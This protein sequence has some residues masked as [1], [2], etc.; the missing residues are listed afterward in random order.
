MRHTRLSARR[1]F[2]AICFAL[3]LCAAEARADHT[4]Y[5]DFTTRGFDLSEYGI[6]DAYTV[7]AVKSLIRELM[8][9]D[10]ASY[11]VNFVT[12][13]PPNGRYTRVIFGGYDMRSGSS[14][15]G[16]V[17][18]D[19][20]DQGF[21]GTGLGSWQQDESV[22]FV[23]SD[24]FST[25]VEWQG[26]DATA[27]RI[28][29][30]IAGTASHELGHILS[31]CHEN[32]YDDG[33]A[34]GDTGTDPDVNEH[35]M[36]TGLTG[37]QSDDRA[38]ADRFFSYH[39][40]SN[41]LLEAVQTRC[42]HTAMG[43]LNNSDARADLLYGRFQSP[44]EVRWYGRKSSG[45]AFGDY[46]TW[47]T[48]GGDAD[49]IFLAGDVDNDK[50]A[51]LVYGRVFSATKV[52]WYVRKSDGTKFGD[53]ATWATDA[54]D[55]G[56]IFRLADVNAD[57]RADLVYGR[58]F[59]S[60]QVTWYVRKS[61]GSSFGDYET[62]VTDGGDEGNIFFVA[63]V[64][65]NKRADLVYGYIF[66]PTQ[67]TWYVRKSSGSSFGGYETWVTDGGDEGDRFLVADLDADGDAD[68]AYGR[69][70]GADFSDQSVVIWYARKS[71]GTK[72]GD[73]TTWSSDAGDAGDTFRI[74][75]L[76]GDKRADLL[77]GRKI[78]FDTVKWYARNSSGSG[79]GG[80]TIWADN[81]SDEGDLI[82]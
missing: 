52:T 30:A 4:V 69:K 24:Q 1:T 21:T 79:F 47:V 54:G 48:D 40:S 56:D 31:L 71:D 66:S 5:L 49:D 58:V 12:F 81:A 3:G 55:A 67:V 7:E 43:S 27:P 32:A 9:A 19:A 39:V 26:W 64:N 70:D 14:S 35:I 22:A 18:A 68:L 6:N 59:S 2:L 23:F 80:Y 8:H 29:N 75:D 10:Y 53:Y 72:F 37:L 50:D 76:T 11:E 41:I 61:N 16:T 63:D 46:T 51:D 77:Y 38:T 78:N 13:Q 34:C 33:P 74:A 44:T 73:Y 57:G 25:E 45:T 36:A 42:F 28:S 20:S 62:W 60:T 82:P 65:N 17:S 15:Y